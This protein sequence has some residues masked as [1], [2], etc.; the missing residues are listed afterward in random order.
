MCSIE[1]GEEDEK[2]HHKKREVILQLQ[3]STDLEGNE[4]EGKDD[5]DWKQ[6]AVT[7]KE[8][9]RWWKKEEMQLD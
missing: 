8:H 5:K 9:K 1:R 7:W 2:E 3:D 4:E 6:L